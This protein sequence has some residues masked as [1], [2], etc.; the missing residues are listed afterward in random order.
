MSSPAS[1]E[2]ET[3]ESNFTWTQSPV[4]P[5]LNTP[6]PGF[7]E[8]KTRKPRAKLTPVQPENVPPLD[9]SAVSCKSTAGECEDQSVEI[10]PATVLST[11]GQERSVIVST[12]AVKTDPE[13]EGADGRNAAPPGG[14]SSRKKRPCT[15][16][17][18]KGKALLQVEQDEPGSSTDSQKS[19]TGRPQRK[20]PHSCVHSIESRSYRPSRRF[21]FSSSSGGK[22]AR[23]QNCS[24][25]NQ[26]AR[27]SPLKTASDPGSSMIGPRPRLD[28]NESSG[29]RSEDE[30]LQLPRRAFYSVGATCDEFEELHPRVYVGRE[31]EPAYVTQD[32]DSSVPRPRDTTR[33]S[34]ASF[35]SESIAKSLKDIRRSPYNQNLTICDSNFR[36]PFSA[37]K[38]RQK[39]AVTGGANDMKAHAKAIPAKDS[40]LPKSKQPQRKRTDGVPASTKQRKPASFK[41]PGGPRQKPAPKRSQP[42]RVYMKSFVLLNDVEFVGNRT[43][44]PYIESLRSSFLQRRQPRDCD[45]LSFCGTDPGAQRLNTGEVKGGD[46]SSREAMNDFSEQYEQYARVGQVPNVKAGYQEDVEYIGKSRVVVLDVETLFL[47]TRFF[48]PF[49]FR[50]LDSLSFEHQLQFLFIT[51]YSAS[52][53]SQCLIVA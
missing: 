46:L 26:P 10:V 36:S 40:V 50:Y 1:P 52:R 30:I 22:P 16:R 4:D 21:L 48:L 7:T 38:V 15:P 29:V 32:S 8:V 5:S 12:P 18:P 25:P 6:G 20:L 33:I 2:L 23:R 51:A 19:F 49:I 35:S 39:G 42:R 53:D 34:S 45:E 24:S 37:A 3:K 44:N 11:R 27:P 28:A 13:A 43:F 14:D 41:P 9:L 17:Y 47:R 31:E